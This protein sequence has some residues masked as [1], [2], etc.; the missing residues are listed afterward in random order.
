MREGAYHIHPSEELVD[1]EALQCPGEDEPKF[2][3]SAWGVAQ[4]LPAPRSLSL[5][6]YMLSRLSMTVPGVAEARTDFDG[7]CEEFH[8]HRVV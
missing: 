1:V 4:S 6:L 5:R 3:R 7:P 8:Q 2:Q